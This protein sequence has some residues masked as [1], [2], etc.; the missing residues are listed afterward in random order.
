MAD[1]D[2]HA[3]AAALVEAVV[4]PDLAASAAAGLN[5]AHVQVRALTA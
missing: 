1:A 3:A 5:Y 4:A 2:R